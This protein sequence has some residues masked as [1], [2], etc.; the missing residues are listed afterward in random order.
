MG[1]V[2]ARPLE[3][4][5][6]ILEENDG[7]LDRGGGRRWGCG[8][9]CRWVRGDVGIVTTMEHHSTKHSQGTVAWCELGTGWGCCS[10]WELYHHQEQPDHTCR[11]GWH[12]DSLIRQAQNG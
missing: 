11:H 7:I 2:G 8:K 12:F 9:G 3:E 1:R 5:D 4:N 10:A 6:G